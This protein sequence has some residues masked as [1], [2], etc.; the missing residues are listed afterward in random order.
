MVRLIWSD[1]Q[2]VG[3]AGAMV[4]IGL[5]DQHLRLVHEPAKAVECTIRSRS[6]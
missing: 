5:R 1:F 3:Q 6:R 2:R 4:V